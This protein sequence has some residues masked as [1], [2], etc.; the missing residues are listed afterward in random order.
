MQQIAEIAKM[1]YKLPI[2]HE[3][4]E[5]ARS[6][7]GFAKP[8]GAGGGDMIMLVG[9]LPYDELELRIFKL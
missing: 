1:P 2:H 6:N 3:V 4:E 7:G 9:D 8:T 5:W